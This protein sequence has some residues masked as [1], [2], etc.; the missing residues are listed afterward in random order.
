M[1]NLPSLMYVLCCAVLGGWRAGTIGG[2]GN[3]NVGVAGVNWKVKL[4]ACKFLDSTGSGS[5]S[6]GILCIQWC[7]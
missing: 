1:C 6:N 4:L 7:R 2:V 5:L 3:N